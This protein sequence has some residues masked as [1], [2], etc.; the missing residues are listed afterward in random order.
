MLQLTNCSFFSAV[1]RTAE[2]APSKEQSYDY[3]VLCVKALPDLYDL[4]DIIHSVVTPEHTCILVNTTSTLG[5][6]AELE[7]RFPTNVILSLVS[8]IDIVQT[9]PSEFEHMASSDIWVGPASRTA[10]IP[11]AIQ[12][13]MATA[14]S[15]T[16]NT[17]QVN[18][19]VSQNIRQEQFERMIG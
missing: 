19:K 13:D 5:V 6:E 9:G 4:G 17:A 1:V 16:L 10:T 11:S 2:E 8:G 7:N 3:V 14:L 12:N 15:I 18:C